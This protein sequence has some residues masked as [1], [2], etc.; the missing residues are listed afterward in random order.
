M[1]GDLIKEL[2][3]TVVGPTGSMAA[4]L[5]LADHAEID[6]AMMDIHIRG[7]K[8]FPVAERLAARG[9]P[10]MFTTGYAGWDGPEKW[11]HHLRLAK[12]YGRDAVERH[13]LMLVGAKAKDAR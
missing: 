9:I 5:E 8:V 13:L 1:T 12:P 7:A 6:A 11:H 2:G 10:F 4:A 3:C